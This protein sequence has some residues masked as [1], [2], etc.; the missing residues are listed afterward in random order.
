M[1]WNTE[2]LPGCDGTCLIGNWRRLDKIADMEH[3]LARKTVRS[4]IVTDSYGISDPGMNMPGAVQLVITAKSRNV[5][6][7]PATSERYQPSGPTHPRLDDMGPEL[8]DGAGNL[9]SCPK[10]PNASHGNVLLG[11]PGLEPV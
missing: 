2:T 5:N 3:S 1:L 6:R 11:Q 9:P 4:Q 10:V 8:A 7:K